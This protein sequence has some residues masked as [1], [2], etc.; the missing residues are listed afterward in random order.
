[1]WFTTIGGFI[2]WLFNRCKTKLT[3]EIDGLGKGTI[4]KTRQ[5]ENWLIGILFSAIMIAI[6]VLVNIV[7]ENNK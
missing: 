6:I 7:K 3:D 5:T 2:R 4:L 1:M